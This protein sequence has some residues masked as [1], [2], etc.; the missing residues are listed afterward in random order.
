MEGPVCDYLMV[1]TRE[2]YQRFLCPFVYHPRA[3]TAPNFIARGVFY[4]QFGHQGIP[5]RTVFKLDEAAAAA[6]PTRH[7]RRC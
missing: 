6:M 4:S 2:D 7:C 1:R 3:A 5:R